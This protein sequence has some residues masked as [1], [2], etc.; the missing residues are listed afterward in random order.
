MVL[1]AVEV[2]ASQDCLQAQLTGSSLHGCAHHGRR[3]RERGRRG[4]EREERER[5]GGQRLALVPHIRV[6]SYIVSVNT[7]YFV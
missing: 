5:E 1:A 2:D 6:R 7:L 3:G 4:R